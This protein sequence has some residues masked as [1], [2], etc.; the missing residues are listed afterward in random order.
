M[1]SVETVET[2]EVAALFL[3]LI[4]KVYVSHCPLDI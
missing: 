1:T 4:T 3:G 2:A